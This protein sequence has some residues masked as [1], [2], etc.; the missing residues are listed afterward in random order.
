MKPFAIQAHNLKPTN[1]SFATDVF[2]LDG[3]YKIM[4]ES[5]IKGRK[6]MVFKIDMN[7]M[8]D[9]PYVLIATLP[10]KSVKLYYENDTLFVDKSEPSFSF[11]LLCYFS[12]FFSIKR[13]YI[14]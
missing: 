1:K 10:A 5:L 8:K 2:T 4:D 13:N 14:C 12:T 6:S 7:K 9:T 11:G 3:D